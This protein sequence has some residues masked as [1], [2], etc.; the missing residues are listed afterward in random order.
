ME[1]EEQTYDMAICRLKL[2]LQGRG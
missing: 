1:M 2:A